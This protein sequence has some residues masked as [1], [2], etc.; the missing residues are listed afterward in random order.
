MKISIIV[1]VGNEAEWKT[2]EAS[3]HESIAAAGDKVEAELLPC[4]D[5]EHKGAYVARNEGLRRATG[6]WIAW[7]DCDD[8]VE[9]EWL[10]EIAGAIVRV[11]RGERV[12]VIQF[13][14]TEVKDGKTR[15]LTY[16]T[17]GLVSGEDFARELLRNDGMPAWLW[18]RVFRRELFDGASF[19]GRVKQDYQMFLQ[20]LPR[21]RQVWSIGKPLYRYIRHG[22]GLSNYVQQMDYRA[23]G[24]EFEALIAKLPAAWLTDAQ[25]GLALTMAD[26]AVHSKGDNG[27][28]FFVRKYLGAVLLDRKV[29]FRLKIKALLA[30]LR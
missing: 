9:V 7:V 22:R 12:D 26:V 25:I 15:P 3:L 30:A 17:Q 2:C 8:V 13:D 18:T 14:A 20:I 24:A 11:E 16:A 5:L 1:P 6:D 27:S 21:I 23:A 10:S 29:P 19:N 4:W 28:R